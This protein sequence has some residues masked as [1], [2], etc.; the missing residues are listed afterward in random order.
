M[1]SNLPFLIFFSPWEQK[2]S[3]QSPKTDCEISMPHFPA[4]AITCA[5]EGTC[6]ETLGASSAAW[7]LLARICC[8]DRVRKC[9][10]RLSLPTRVGNGESGISSSV[11]NQPASEPETM[12]SKEVEGSQG[13]PLENPDVGQAYWLTAKASSGSEGPSRVVPV[14]SV[15]GCLLPAVTAV[16][17]FSAPTQG[18]SSVPE[19]ETT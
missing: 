12:S 14:L 9:T 4:T 17:V 15:Q 6:V 19:L 18:N 7:P 10:S 16:V 8:A 1:D 5:G 2:F 3:Y 13:P 11:I